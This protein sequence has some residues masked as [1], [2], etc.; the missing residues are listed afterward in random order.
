[1]RLV[2]FF[3]S[4]FGPRERP[5]PAEVLRSRD[6]NVALVVLHPRCVHRLPVY[7][8]HHDLWIELPGREGKERLRRPPTEPIVA[9][10]DKRN[11]RRSTSPTIGN[12]S[13]LRIKDVNVPV[14][15]DRNGWL[16]LIAG[17]VAE[18]PLRREPRRCQC[19]R[20]GQYQYE[21]QRNFLRSSRP[22]FEAAV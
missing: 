15:V 2:G 8:V 21:Q 9:A 22:G 1:H 4:A 12:R 3:T 7:W 17:V 13:I 14:A 20:C 16:P 5:T 10:N 6:Y 19:R 18:A 11:A